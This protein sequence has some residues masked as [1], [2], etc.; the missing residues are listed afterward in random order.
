MKKNP[1]KALIIIGVLLLI[2]LN[3][4]IG[5]ILINNDKKKEDTDNKD[6]VSPDTPQVG[7]GIPSGVE[8]A[9]I[10]D[11]LI[12]YGKIRI[13]INDNMVRFTKSDFNWNNTPKIDGYILM[14]CFKIY[15]DSSRGHVDMDVSISGV[16][17]D[18]LLLYEYTDNNWKELKRYG[19]EYSSVYDLLSDADFCYY[20]K[21]SESNS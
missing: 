18:N 11:D 15:T 8:V 10:K 14:K 3:V 6:I 4:C 16:S 12:M 7:D 20:I 19:S 13:R 9:V 5:V 1:K 21:N 2:I 17:P